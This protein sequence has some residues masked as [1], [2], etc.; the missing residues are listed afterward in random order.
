MEQIIADISAMGFHR[1]QVMGVINELQRSGQN[2]D[3]NVILD[4]LMNQQ[5]GARGGGY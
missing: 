1:Q 2:V 5:G 4:R 3:L